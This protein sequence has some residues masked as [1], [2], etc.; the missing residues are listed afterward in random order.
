MSDKDAMVRWQG[1]A[2]ES[3]TAVVSHFLTYAAAILAFQASILIDSE[4][5]KIEWPGTYVIGGSLALISLIIGSIVVLI[6]LRDARLTARTARYRDTGR[7]QA[8]IDVLRDKTDYLGTWT[9]RLI[10]AQVVTFTVSALLFI[11]WVLG[12]N[13]EKLYVVAG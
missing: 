6:R 8:E 1:N 10:P 4:I 2:R 7:D 3:R 5:S 9:N 12:S 11:V 13:W